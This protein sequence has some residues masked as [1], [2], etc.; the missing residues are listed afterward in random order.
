ML[1]KRKAYGYLDMLTL[2]FETAPLLSALSA[3]MQILG[4]LLPA[5]QVFA[6]ARFVNAAIAVFQETAEMSDVYGPVAMP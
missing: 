3:A 6:T 2:A 4:A 1:L 5:V